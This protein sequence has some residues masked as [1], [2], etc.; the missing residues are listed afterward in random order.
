MKDRTP[1]RV[2]CI[3]LV[4]DAKSY[5]DNA[6]IELK[7]IEIPGLPGTSLL[8]AS[9]IVTLTLAEAKHSEPFLEK[10]RNNGLRIAH[11]TYRAT[12]SGRRGLMP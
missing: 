2:L 4:F 6:K 8:P 10:Q 12:R 5:S 1:E 11:C 9:E 7:K 3:L